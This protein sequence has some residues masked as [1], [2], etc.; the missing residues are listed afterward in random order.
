MN[1]KLGFLCF[2]MAI[3][4]SH[5]SSAATASTLTLAFSDGEDSVEKNYR[6]SGT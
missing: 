1:F 2:T 6:G 3:L 5:Q 4:A